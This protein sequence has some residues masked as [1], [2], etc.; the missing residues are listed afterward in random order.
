MIVAQQTDDVVD[1]G[2][3]C[4]DVDVV[5]VADETSIPSPTPTT[6]PPPPSQELP[7]TSQ[8]AQA[9]EIIKLK[10]RVK[11]LE[12]KNKLKVSGLRRLKKVGTSQRIESSADT[13][14]DDPEDASKQGGIMEL[15][16]AD[17]DVNLEN[18]EK[19]ADV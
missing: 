13:V 16:D 12:R 1:K 9:L 18:V 8:V 7:S 4:V 5:P 3:A 2:D 11:N 14:M 10:Q 19:D 6:Q 15:I 17:K